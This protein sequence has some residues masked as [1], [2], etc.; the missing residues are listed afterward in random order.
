[1]IRFNL[2]KAGSWTRQDITR[3][4]GI[5]MP[6]RSTRRGMESDASEPAVDRRKMLNCLC[7]LVGIG[8]SSRRLHTRRRAAKIAMRNGNSM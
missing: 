8:N 7:F 2:P 3:H 1:M 6:Q 5:L 4:K